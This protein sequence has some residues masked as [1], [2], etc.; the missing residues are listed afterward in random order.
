MKLFKFINSIYWFIR[1]RTI[2]KY[3]VIKTELK[4]NYYEIDYLMVHGMFSLLCRFVEKE[5]SGLNDIK[6][7]INFLQKS[8][9]EEI[10]DAISRDDHEQIPFISK[11][12][13]DEIDALNEVIRLYEWWKNIYPYYDDNDPYFGK[14]NNEYIEIESTDNGI[15]KFRTNEKIEQL[16]ND[17]IKYQKNTREVITKNLISLINIRMYLI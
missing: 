4:P 6:L 5:Y 8:K 16:I 10:Q 2:D 15:L 1:Y 17:S 13:D 3:H 14:N 9:I 11:Q 12:T 7:R